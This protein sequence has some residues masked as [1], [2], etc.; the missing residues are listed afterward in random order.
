MARRCFRC[1][2]YFAKAIHLSGLDPRRL[3]LEITE[4]IFIADVEKTMATLHG[5]RNLGVRI[6]LDDF[7]TGYSSLS[8]L[9]SFPFEKVK[10]DRSF[11]EDLRG[12]GNG[13]AVIRAIT[14]LADALGMEA[15]AEGGEEVAQFETLEREG[16]RYIQGYLF[17][18]PVAGG[19]VLDLLADGAGYQ[20][21]LVG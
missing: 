15:L 5:L 18:R 12:D 10:I 20:R 7:G 13:H 6:A 4:S 11:V 3:E 1:G 17:S 9:R 14:T 21:Q 19:A 8:Y 16:C 2:H